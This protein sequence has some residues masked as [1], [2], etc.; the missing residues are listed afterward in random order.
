MLPLPAV[1]VTDRVA[2]VT[3]CGLIG[4]EAVKL[5]VTRSHG[6]ARDEVELLEAIP[7]EVRVGTGAGEARVKL[8]V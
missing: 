3:V 6:F 4:S 1:T 2:M 5:R 8:K 7:T